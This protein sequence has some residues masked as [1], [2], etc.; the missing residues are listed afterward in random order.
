MCDMK[1]YDGFVVRRGNEYL[2]AVPYDTAMFIRW[3]TS[4]WEGYHFHRRRI[5]KR[6]ADRVG[7][8]VCF[9]NQVSGIL[10]MEGKS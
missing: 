6:V 5:A 8:D 4:P 10:K 3:S 7:G 9:F 1:D 2:V